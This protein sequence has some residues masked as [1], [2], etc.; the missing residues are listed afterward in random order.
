M[1]MV[2]AAVGP[3]NS[4]RW[5]LIAILLVAYCSPILYFAISGF[6]GINPTSGTFDDTGVLQRI[7]DFSEKSSN[8]TKL[9]HQMMLPL[10]AAI[11]AS[12]F[13]HRTSGMVIYSF[14]LVISALALVASLFC[15]FLYS[16]AFWPGAAVNFALFSDVASSLAVYVMLL[17]GLKI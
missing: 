11:T 17:V 2:P 13:V 6:I 7:T 8:L 5:L 9:F 3:T 14:F 15:A 16:P 4:L 12:T 1:A 10:L